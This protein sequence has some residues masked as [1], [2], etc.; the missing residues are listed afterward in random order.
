MKTK[1]KKEKLIPELRFPEFKEEWKNLNLGYFL[2]FKNGANAPKSSY[3]RGYK[4]I[5]VLDIINNPHIT[6]DSIRQEVNISKDIFE[7]NN[8][9]YGDILFQ[10]SSETPEEVGQSNVY[11]DEEKPA[12]FGGFVIRGK[13][14]KEYNPLYFNYLLKTYK[15]RK[16]IVIRGCGSTHFNIGQEDLRETP[17]IISSNMQEQQKIS[18]FLSLIDRKI[19]LL[20]KKKELLEIYKKGVMQKIFNRDIRFKDINGNNYPEWEEKRL[21]E[22]FK[23]RV[24]KG[25][26]DLELLSVTQDRGVIRRTE[27]D[28][29]DNSNSDKRNYKRVL[30]NDIV[31][32]SMR[33]WQ[34]ASGLSNYEGIVSPAYTVIYTDENSNFY[35][36]LFKYPRVVYNFR[37]YSQ[38]LTSDTWNLKYP[39]FSE[40]KVYKPQ[41]EEQTKI[42]TFLPQLDKL[43]KGIHQQTGNVITFKRGLLQKM[44][45]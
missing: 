7:K 34:A 32:N 17:I 37:R 28:A 12:T 5:N 25:R 21:G 31:Y 33:M 19:E 24:E 8:V 14:I 9:E 27:I 39:L 30:P 29:V 22:I 23:E 26:D 43:L 41:L 1:N 3:G 20:N 18:S 38:G 15:A 42:A 35:R 40:V 11:L 13:K 44:F 2:S 16:E 45:V 6:Y 36:Y 10:R 4:F